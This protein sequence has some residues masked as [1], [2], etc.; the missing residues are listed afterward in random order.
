MEGAPTQ[1][2][3]PKRSPAAQLGEPTA[4]AKVVEPSPQKAEGEGPSQIEYHHDGVDTR[5]NVVWWREA[6]VGSLQVLV[7][8]SL[9]S[10]AGRTWDELLQ[11]SQ[12][13]VGSAPLH[14]AAEHH[15]VDA[16]RV[17]ASSHA[18][19]YTENSKVSD[20]VPAEPVLHEEVLLV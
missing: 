3:P 9:L 8:Q 1:I 6:C 11:Q 16:W 14:E 13:I 15:P 20:A 17:W 19:R 10:A 7:Y 4:S 18:T 5:M 2:K 12:K